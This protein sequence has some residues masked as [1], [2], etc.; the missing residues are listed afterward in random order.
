MR[1]KAKYYV[2]Y[3]HREEYPISVM[4]SFFGVSRS[5]YYAFV[6]VSA[7]DKMKENAEEKM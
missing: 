3:R 1:P 2:I 4:C 5:G 7:N 6:H